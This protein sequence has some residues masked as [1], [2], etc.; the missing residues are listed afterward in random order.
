M[1]VSTSPNSAPVNSAA[2]AGSACPRAA[3]LSRALKV[4]GVA[5]FSTIDLP[6]RLSS[7]VFVQGCAWNCGYCHNPHLQ[8]RPESSP[9]EWSRILNLLERRVGLLDGVVFSGGEPC[10]DP[11]LEDAIGDVRELGFQVGLHTAG[12]YTARLDN[13]LPLLDW[14][15]LDIKAPFEHYERVTGV[16]DSGRA[17]RRSAELLLASGVDYELRTTLHPDLLSEAD[18]EHLALMLAQMGAR[19]YALQVFRPTG[20]AD[21]PLNAASLADYPGQALLDRIA[22]FFQQFTVRRG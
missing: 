22:P 12:I 9:M 11:A 8:T 15:G 16:P 2:P 3:P 1:S 17:A 6:G 4:G 19:N 5:P 18:I 10:I 13:L 20:C 7:V 14:V 21:A